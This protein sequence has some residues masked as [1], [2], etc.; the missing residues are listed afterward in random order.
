MSG[1][2]DISP[3]E[4]TDLAWTRTGLGLVSVS[5]LVCARALK[6]GAPALLAVGGVALVVGLVVLTVLAPLRRRML[7]STADDVAAPWVMAAATVAVV[8]VTV[9]AGVAVM[10]LPIR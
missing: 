10:T 6:S 4:R 9:A 1:R 3:A 7:R 2:A 8:L 5:G